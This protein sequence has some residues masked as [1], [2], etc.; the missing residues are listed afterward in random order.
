[1]SAVSSGVLLCGVCLALT[2]RSHAQRRPEPEAAPPDVAPAPEI[3]PPPAAGSTVEATAPDAA[4]LEDPPEVTPA[5]HP[6][7]LPAAQSR[8]DEKAPDGAQA[9]AP[10]E[11]APSFG[12]AGSA[13]FGIQLSGHVQFWS[14]SDASRVGA[15][16]APSFQYFV[17]RNLALGFEITLSYEVDRGY[18]ADSSLVQV[19]SSLLSAAPS[20][21]WNVPLGERWSFFPDVALGLHHSEQHERLLS[22]R[23][24]SVVGSET[25]AAS[26]VRTGPWFSMYA[27]LLFQVAPHFVLGFGPSVYHD[28]A[29]A[30]S[31]TRLGAER[32]SLGASL[33]VGGFWGGDAEH[34]A[35]VRYSRTAGARFGARHSTVLTSGMSLSGNWATYSGSGA[36]ERSISV[37]PALDWFVVDDISIGAQLAYQV[38]SYLGYQSD[39][40]TVTYDVNGV[41]ASVRFGVHAR[42]SD[43][44]SCYPTV[45]LGIG[46]DNSDERSGAA[47]NV[48][49]R[50]YAAWSLSSPLLVHIASHYFIGLGPYLTHE[51]K[52]SEEREILAT[53][54]G[55]SSVAG[56]WL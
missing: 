36:R 5:L 38:G 45:A 44:V 14:G 43:H 34:G 30:V 16:L 48:Y 33:M 4:A 40:S 55:I 20:F 18:G 54:L 1:V 47:R 11:I 50:E 2:I 37:G 42:I 15:R 24:L 51:V 13:A 17:T 41:G 26:I 7:Q 32:T 12:A 25:G 8:D 28:F 23:S 3:P 31:A 21:G 35:R 46:T 39:G 52:D 56:G 10:Y 49:A 19:R 53:K 27:P 22:G 6:T 29:R 9:E